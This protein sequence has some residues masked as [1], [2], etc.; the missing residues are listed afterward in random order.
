M[1]VHD[2]S[3]RVS[4]TVAFCPVMTILLSMFV[5]IVSDIRELETTPLALTFSE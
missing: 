5:S 1:Q 2:S 3:V 4:P